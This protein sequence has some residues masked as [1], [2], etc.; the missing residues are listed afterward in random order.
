MFIAHDL[1]LVRFLCERIGVMYRGN[2]VELKDSEDLFA[3]PVHD[4]TRELLAAQPV[5]DP[6]EERMRR[7][8]RQRQAADTDG[9]ALVRAPEQRR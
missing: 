3:N 1:S 2:L 4:H 6:A 7:E 9:A 5:P 8:I